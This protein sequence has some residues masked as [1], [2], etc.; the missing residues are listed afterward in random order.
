MQD[1]VPDRNE[2]IKTHMSSLGIDKD[3]FAPD[4]LED[5]PLAC[6]AFVYIAG[7]KYRGL[8][9]RGRS[10]QLTRR[11]LARIEW[12]AETEKAER[13]SPLKVKTRP[14]PTA[15]LRTLA[16]RLAFGEGRYAETLAL[17]DAGNTSELSPDNFAAVR[18]LRGTA[19]LKFSVD[20][21]P[22]ADSRSAADGRAAAGERWRSDLAEGLSAA[23]AALGSL[24]GL[25]LAT[26]A[27]FWTNDDAKSDTEADAEAKAEARARAEAK[28]TSEVCLAA[29]EAVLFDPQF[30]W[31][32]EQVGAESFSSDL[33]YLAIAAIAGISHD[34]KGEWARVAK[35]LF[36]YVSRAVRPATIETG[37]D[38]LL[39]GH[40]VFGVVDDALSS[41]DYETAL[42]AA[43]TA[44]DGRIGVPSL[45]DTA[46]G[47][48][49]ASAAE[50]PDS[51]PEERRAHHK[52]AREHLLAAKA[53]DTGLP[54]VVAKLEDLK[55]SLSADDPRREDLSAHIA[56]LKHILEQ[57]VLP[58]LSKIPPDGP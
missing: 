6:A 45:I 47:R 17:I 46:L 24:V 27:R 14:L 36:A 22:A 9:D 52:K 49:H 12:L 11:L 33:P 35:C 39:A 56:Q 38:A 5:L 41:K 30:R 29:L 48:A 18:I 31:F 58:S 13:N 43:Q 19:A 15:V 32:G 1:G 8:V 51:S 2:T 40:W 28:A 53:E 4:T 42:R 26:P 37:S 55:K 54:G 16:A 20:T 7:H 44:H 23:P 50:N 34:D 57:V 10:E 3:H 25:L 21:R